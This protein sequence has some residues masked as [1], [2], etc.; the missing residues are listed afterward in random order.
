M[1]K[2]PDSFDPRCPESHGICETPTDLDRTKPEPSGRPYLRQ[3]EEA[4]QVGRNHAVA[5][6]RPRTSAQCF[7]SSDVEVFKRDLKRA[8]ERIDCGRDGRPLGPQDA[9]IEL[10]VEECDLEAVGRGG[11]PVRAGHAVDEPFEAEPAEVAGHLGSGVGPAEQRFDLR[12]EIAIAEAADQVRE[13][14]ERL[15]QGHHPRVP[16]TKRGH[17]L[18]DLDGEPLQPV[19]GV[20]GEHAVVTDAFGFEELPVDAFP[21]VA[22]ERQ[23]VDG[24]ADVEVLRVVDRGLRPAGVLFF[25]ILF[26]VRVLVLD[27]EAV[28]GRAGWLFRTAPTVSDSE[29]DVHQPGGAPRLCVLSSA[30]PLNLKIEM[31]VNPDF[32]FGRGDFWPS[33]SSSRLDFRGFRTRHPARMGDTQWVNYKPSHFSSHSTGF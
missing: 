18:A 17:A 14:G 12:T 30:F 9:E 11:V 4:E 5:N 25:E 33:E 23:V 8:R 6:G 32:R 7:L 24:L 27:V 22:V 19:Q 21:E 13:A 20:L 29:R 26:D 15:A 1:P 10:A 28:P 16:E 31:P 3:R 2:R